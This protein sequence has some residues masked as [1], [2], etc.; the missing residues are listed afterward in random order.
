MSG[1]RAPEVA[2]G[3]WET[4]FS[5]LYDRAHAYLLRNI[6]LLSDS[7]LA[8]L[9]HDLNLAR[10]VIF[11]ELKTKLNFWKWFPWRLAAL[12]HCNEQKARDHAR[13]IVPDWA[14]MDKTADKH[15]PL[16]VAVM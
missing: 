11:D 16:T 12:A 2:A 5:D 9:M 15:H 13:A 1:L 4:A 10:V 8:S 6:G 14:G 7:Q 3:D